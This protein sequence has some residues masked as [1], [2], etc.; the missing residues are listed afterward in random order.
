MRWPHYEHVFFDCDSTLTTVEGI[1]ILAESSGKQWRVEVLTQA[2]MDGDLELQEVYDKR[3]RALRP[4]HQQIRDIKRAYKQNVVEDVK[5]TIATLQELEHKV[6]IISGG[7]LEPVREFGVYLGVPADHIRAVGVT[8]NELS[9]E[10]WVGGDEQY[11]TYD[12]GAL[13]VSDGKA[14]IVQEFLAGKRGR[15]LL[16]GDGYSDLLAGS[17]VNLFT[18]FGG[19]TQRSRVSQEAPIYVQSASIAPILAVAAGPAMVSGLNKTPHKVLG[20]KSLELIRKGAIRF[21]NERY[22]ERFSKAIDATYQAVYS[23]PDGGTAGDPGRPGALDD[24][25]SHAG[26]R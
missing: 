11:M 10:W 14:E 8:Y 7:L 20:Q 22:K 1:D 2:A 18:G 13:T 6:Y 16:V 25:A 15:S 21:N 26:M 19:V 12:D 3:L 4:T 23:R 24:W 5:E 9:G 17:A